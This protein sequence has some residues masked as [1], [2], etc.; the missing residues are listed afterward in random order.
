[1]PTPTANGTGVVTGHKAVPVC[2]EIPRSKA[3][4]R[5]Q[6]FLDDIEMNQ[7]SRVKVVIRVTENIVSICIASEIGPLA[8]RECPYN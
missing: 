7:R 2:C 5:C 8:S 3:L 6:K 1:M 4:V